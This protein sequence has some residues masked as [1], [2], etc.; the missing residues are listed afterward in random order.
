MIT[1]SLTISKETITFKIIRISPIEKKIVK[2]AIIVLKNK[3]KM[4]HRLRKLY[5]MFWT[6][7]LRWK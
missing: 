5:M 3:K 1:D 6:T 7:I 2:K 4:Q